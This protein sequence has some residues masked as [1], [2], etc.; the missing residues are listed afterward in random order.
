M[1]QCHNIFCT[2]C[3]SFTPMG[4]SAHPVQWLV[5]NPFLWLPFPGFFPYSSGALH[6]SRGSLLHFS[7]MLSIP[8][9]P[10]KKVCL[11]NCCFSQHW[12]QP[13]IVSSHG[14]VW[15]FCFLTKPESL[16]DRNVANKLGRISDTPVTPLSHDEWK[17]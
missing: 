17:C 12:C 13:G 8:N 10:Y 14:L 9:M 5:P 15:I 2:P 11:L 6:T 4:E 16:V 3:E 1:H 7:L